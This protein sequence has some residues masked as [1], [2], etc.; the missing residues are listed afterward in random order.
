MGAGYHTLHHTLYRD[1]YGQFFVFF[2]WVHDTL[3]SPEAWE[4]TKA[5]GAA[6]AAGADKAAPAPRSSK[7]GKVGGKAE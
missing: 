6:K 3:T 7:K 4:A 1:N 2:D 5:A